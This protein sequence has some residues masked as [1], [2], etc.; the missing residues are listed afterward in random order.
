MKTDA[1]ERL[2]KWKCGNRARSV[3]ISK[4]DGYGASC[5]LVEL[6][7]ESGN[8]QAYEVQFLSFPG[9]K[10]RF[11]LECMLLGTVYIPE[12]EESDDRPGLAKTIHF[13]I[14]AFEKGI[15]KPR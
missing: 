10:E 9:E 6:R 8:T 15:W 4:D 12:D 3:T 7:H 5:W 2:E 13:A 1:I 11:I 14:D